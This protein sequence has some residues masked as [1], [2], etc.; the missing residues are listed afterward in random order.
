MMKLTIVSI[1][2]L[3]LIVSINTNP[4][5][6][7]QRF[8]NEELSEYED[9]SDLQS[10][11]QEFVHEYGSTE[12]AP[13]TGAKKDDSG[14]FSRMKRKLKKFGSQTKQYATETYENTK[15]KLCK[16]LYTRNYN[17]EIVKQFC[18]PEKDY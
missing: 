12:T 1:F 5:S 18:G 14:W 4:S 8:R 9:T 10:L 11:Y 6:N 7:S 2:L 17:Y 16:F 3:V 13:T 15:K